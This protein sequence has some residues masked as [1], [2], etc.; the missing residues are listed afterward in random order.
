MN[1]MNDDIKSFNKL[2]KQCLDREPNNIGLRCQYVVALT[3]NMEYEKSYAYLIETLKTL[4]VR[5]QELKLKTAADT[6]LD[7][8]YDSM[9]MIKHYRVIC[10]IGCAS[11]RCVFSED[12]SVVTE[13]LKLAIDNDQSDVGVLRYC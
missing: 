7:S 2:L 11:I 9:Q 5:E 3:T 4:R 1:Y 8:R 10:G 12:W 6:K 13:H